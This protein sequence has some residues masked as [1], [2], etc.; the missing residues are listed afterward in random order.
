MSYSLPRNVPRF[1]DEQ[2]AY[3]NTYWA[4]RRPQQNRHA[5]NGSIGLEAS[6]DGHFDHN[7][8][9]MYKDKPYDYGRSGRYVPL[10]R[11]KRFWLAS[12]LAILF[13]IFVW[14]IL[15]PYF[16]P[17]REDGRSK[18][19]WKWMKGSSEPDW[20]LRRE[21]VKEAFKISWDAYSDNAWGEFLG[22]PAREQSDTRPCS[23]L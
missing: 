22:N 10:V 2:R 12:A 16:H 6:F 13:F 3:E 7:S 8:L 23:R 5:S 18:I 19:L 4:A 15:L 17:H 9:P 20:N 14:T 1:D 21:A 11:R